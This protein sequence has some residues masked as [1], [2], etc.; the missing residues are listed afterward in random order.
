[1]KRKIL[2]DIAKKSGKTSEY[3][4]QTIEDMI[5]NAYNTPDFDSYDIIPHKGEKPTVEEFLDFWG[6]FFIELSKKQELY[7]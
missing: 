1:M 5:E 6:K 7:K 4:K 3:L 2:D